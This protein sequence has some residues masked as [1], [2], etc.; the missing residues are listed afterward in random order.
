MSNIEVEQRVS[1]NMH[2]FKYFIIRN[3]LFDIPIFIAPI[4][5]IG[6]NLAYFPTWTWTWT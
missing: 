5:G 1:P 2:V 4:L 3:S 6:V